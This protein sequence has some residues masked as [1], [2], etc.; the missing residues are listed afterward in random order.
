MKKIFSCRLS[1]VQFHWSYM[2]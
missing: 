2:G 1:L